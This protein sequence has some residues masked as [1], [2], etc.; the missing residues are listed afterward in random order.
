MK[1]ENKQELKYV[2]DFYGIP[3]VPIKNRGENVGKVT[4]DMEYIKGCTCALKRGYEH[5]AFELAYE[6]VHAVIDLFKNVNKPFKATDVYRCERSEYVYPDEPGGI[7][8][9][10]VFPEKVVTEEKIERTGTMD[11]VFVNHYKANNSLRYCNGDSYEFQ[12]KEIQEM[13]SLWLKM[14]PEG[15]SFALY[16]GNGIVD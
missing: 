7:S 13:Y 5:Y 15:R 12:D 4:R 9:H 1:I 2:M 3:F 14:M 10:H 6:Q 11:E 16:Y 8:Y